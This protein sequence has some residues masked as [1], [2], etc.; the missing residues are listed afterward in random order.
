MFLT[1]T[2]KV[3]RVALTLAGLEDTVDWNKVGAV[4]DRLR[5][6]LFAL[7]ARKKCDVETN[8]LFSMWVLGWCLEGAYKHR[9]VKTLQVKPTP[10]I[11]H[12]LSQLQRQPLLDRID[13]DV[14]NA[15][16]LGFT[17]IAPNFAADE[18][19][20]AIYAHYIQDYAERRRMVERFANAG[21]HYG[22]VLTAQSY[23]AH[24]MPKFVERHIK[25]EFN[26]PILL[27]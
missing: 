12:S 10:R 13:P 9:S 17:V 15:L 27:G 21:H 3:K 7:A 22:G 6:E 14:V 1:E 16:C 25:V 19:M 26:R 5:L 2:T 4:M 24:F 18:L 11:D 20:A 8:V 23:M